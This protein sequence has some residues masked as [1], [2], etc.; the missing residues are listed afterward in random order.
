[1]LWE[2]CHYHKFTKSTLSVWAKIIIKV[3]HKGKLGLNWFAAKRC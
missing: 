1:M 3:T 2:N